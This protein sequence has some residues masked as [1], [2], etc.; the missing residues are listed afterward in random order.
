MS[1]LLIILLTVLI[2][3][4]TSLAYR[5]QGFYESG[6]K[7]TIE[8]TDQ[9]DLDYSYQKSR[10]TISNK[11]A[12]YLTNTLSCAQEKRDYTTAALDNKYWQ[13]R[14]KLEYLKE[15]GKEKRQLALTLDYK[16]KEFLQDTS[17][18][19]DRLKANLRATYK[20]R[21]SHLLRAVA[22]YNHY[23]FKLNPTK[24]EDIFSG[25][26]EA[27]KYCGALTLSGYSKLAYSTRAV[28][29]TQTVNKLGFSYKPGWQPFNFIRA[30]YIFGYRNSRYE[31]EI[32]DYDYDYRFSKINL[33]TRHPLGKKLEAVLKYEGTRKDCVTGNFDNTGYQIE[34][35]WKYSP[36]KDFYA[37]LRLQYRER[38]YEAVDRLT[39]YK[40]GIELT[41]KYRQPLSLGLILRLS[42]Y[43]F[44]G[45]SDKSRAET[46][47]E[48]SFK[49]TPNLSFL[50]SSRLKDYYNASDVWLSRWRIGI[51]M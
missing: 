46:S 27:E 3:P 50:Y 10:L 30:G 40:N 21:D 19:Y 28:F 11:L 17:E 14:N 39:H 36:S 13:L 23:R 33:Y 2:L 20:N 1:K 12:R 31:E 49:P 24:D 15:K 51:E 8:E 47:A 35:G 7:D 34:N 42:S 25:K 26:L 41:F 43:N 38:L 48:I 4:S 37:K 16:A 6:Q 29:G 5:L 32:T 18:T 45:A 44:P 9:D 22:G